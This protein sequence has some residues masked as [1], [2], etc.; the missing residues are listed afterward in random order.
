MGACRSSAMH[1]KAARAKNHNACL[2]SRAEGTGSEPWQAGLQDAGPRA[3]LSSSHNGVAQ[4]WQGRCAD[5]ALVRMQW[6]DRI[7]G[8]GRVRAALKGSRRKCELTQVGHEVVPWP[9]GGHPLR[10]AGLAQ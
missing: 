5:D 7:R 1:A 6:V 10:Q 9:G 8:G 2:R 3:C 4:A